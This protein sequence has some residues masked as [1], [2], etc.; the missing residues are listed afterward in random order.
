MN[1]LKK[2]LV[3]AMI[4][5]MVLGCFVFSTSA[6]KPEEY[7]EDGLVAWYDASNNSNGDH[8]T[9]A[10]VWKDL[11]GNGNHLDLNKAITD[12]QVTWSTTALNINGATGCY[13]A[14]PEDVATVL[15]GDAYTIEIVT[16]DLNYTATDYITLLSS[17][18]DELSVFIRC[19]ANSTCD[20]GLAGWDGKPYS[21]VILLEYKNQDDNG[22]GNRPM[23]PNAW[24]AFNGHTLSV[25]SDLEAFDGAQDMTGDLN[26]HMYSDGTLLASGESQYN[27]TLDKSVYFGHTA[28]NR[29]WGGEIYAIRIYD[30]ALSQ[31]ELQD[32]AAADEFNY[33]KGNI[34]EPV[35]QYDD[36]DEGEFVTIDWSKYSNDVLIFDAV[37]NMIPTV[38]F[39]AAENISN[40]MYPY[41]SDI[42]NGTAWEGAKIAL[43]ETPTT[44]ADGTVDTAVKFK[45]M[46]EQFITRAG[47]E[48][49]PGDK[50]QYIVLKVTVNGE[51]EDFNM[52]TY[53][54]NMKTSTETEYPT[55]SDNGVDL[56]KQGEVQYLI[57]DVAELFTEDDV[58]YRLYFDVLGLTEGSSVILHEARIFADQ[59]AAYDYAGVVIET[60]PEETEPEETETEAQGTEAQGTEAQG[61]E[62][63]GT[64]AQGTEGTDD[65]GCGS[66]VGFGAAAILAAAAAAVVLKKKD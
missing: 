26:V 44:S 46:Y 8:L 5:S 20:K 7:A 9:D 48:F 65:E 34:I 45:I 23:L 52:T 33:R 50:T 12:G 41:E 3:V 17:A 63:Q 58:L 49:L 18:N 43:S 16:G 54:Y 1:T 28:E 30:R 19:G 10:K 24:E 40:Y 21:E 47:L 53:A 37:S 61:T 59:D 4:A 64:E 29:R 25:T 56:D 31:E 51:F 38:G 42:E 32:N 35:K 60:E 36:S 15:E 57:Y 62:A 39:Y 66:V 14:F 13:I 27:M 55:T 2:L 6:V 11:S 22:D